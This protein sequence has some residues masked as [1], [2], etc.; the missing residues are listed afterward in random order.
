MSRLGRA[1]PYCSFGGR[2]LSGPHRGGLT[3]VPFRRVAGYGQISAS[4]PRPMRQAGD[5]SRG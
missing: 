3:L 2:R 4:V 1:L 5:P